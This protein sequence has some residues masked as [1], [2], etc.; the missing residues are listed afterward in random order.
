M[1]SMPG[2]GVPATL[3][4]IPS[5]IEISSDTGMR[6]DSSHVEEQPCLTRE[7]VPLKSCQR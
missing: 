7:W 5:R 2:T 4:G 6:R 3:G 1:L